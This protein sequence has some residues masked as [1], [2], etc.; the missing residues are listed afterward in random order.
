MLAALPETGRA[1]ADA[2]ARAVQGELGSMARAL[3]TLRDTI[4]PALGVLTTLQDIMAPS[5]EVRHY[6]VAASYVATPDTPYQG[7]R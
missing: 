6:G 5:F 4:A 2:G 1:P 3:A 7:C